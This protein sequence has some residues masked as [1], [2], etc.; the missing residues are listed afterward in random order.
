MIS[1]E[2]FHLQFITDGKGQKTAVILPF[3]EFNELLEDNDLAVIAER[4]HEPSIAH[5]TVI[6]DV[7]LY[8]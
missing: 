2:E 3:D 1:A 5:E 6:G 7:G 8:V 4:K